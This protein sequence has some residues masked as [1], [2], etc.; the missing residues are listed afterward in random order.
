MQGIEAVA[1][2]VPVVFPVHPRTRPAVTR[3][4]T[5]AAMVARGRLRLD[6]SA[7]LPGLRRLDGSARAWC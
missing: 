4:A 3:S 7:G 5:A 2:D 6:R 1:S